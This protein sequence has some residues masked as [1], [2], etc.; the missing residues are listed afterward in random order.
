MPIDVVRDCWV[1][2]IP[3]SQHPAPSTQHPPI[4]R[5]AIGSGTRYRSSWVSRRCAGDTTL[6]P[7]PS[8]CLLFVGGWYCTS[9]TWGQFPPVSLSRLALGVPSSTLSC[10]YSGD[11][12]RLSRGR[13]GFDSRTR[14]EPD[15]LR[16]IARLSTILQGLTAARSTYLPPQP[17][18]I[19]THTL[20]IR[21]CSISV[22]GLRR[23]WAFSFTWLRPQAPE[24][25]EVWVDGRAMHSGAHT[26]NVELWP[27]IDSTG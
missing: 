14:R 12:P 10:S 11:Y 3:P 1:R 19:P 25:C 7:S 21:V 6:S 26:H 5:V 23:C 13:P 9:F 20:D 24:K 8:L 15:V 18:C 17:G 22:H 27:T 2:S 4:V 16:Q